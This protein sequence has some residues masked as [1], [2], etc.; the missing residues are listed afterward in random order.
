MKKEVQKLH[1]ELKNYKKFNSQEMEM[2]FEIWRL[3]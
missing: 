1:I 2:Q 3:F